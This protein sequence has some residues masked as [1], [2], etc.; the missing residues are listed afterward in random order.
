MVLLQDQT[1]IKAA[2]MAIGLQ[3]F[4]MTLTRRPFASRFRKG[5]KQFMP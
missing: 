4:G 1:T 2:I 3:I 5:D